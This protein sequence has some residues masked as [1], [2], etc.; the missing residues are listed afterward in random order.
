VQLEAVHLKLTFLG[1]HFEGRFLAFEQE[2]G[3]LGRNVL[4][5][6][7]ILLDRPALAWHEAPPSPRAAGS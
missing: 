6:V 4:N 3:I 2:C 7:R 1:Y 5:A